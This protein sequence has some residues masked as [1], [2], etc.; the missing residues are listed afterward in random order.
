[1]TIQSLVA[2]INTTILN[3]KYGLG[4]LEKRVLVKIFGPK[5]KDVTAA[6]KKL[7]N[8][9]SFSTNTLIEG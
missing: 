9:F 3:E 7:H 1:M 5:R 8:D 6:W 2:S 4:V